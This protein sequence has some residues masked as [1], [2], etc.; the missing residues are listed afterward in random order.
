MKLTEN[1]R[2]RLTVYQLGKVASAVLVVLA[3]WNVIDAG[4]AAALTSALTAI[5]GLFG[6]GASNVAASTV[7]KQINDGTLDF[8]GSAAQQAVEAMGAVAAQAQASVSDLDKVKAA[9]ADLAGSVPVV[10]PLAQQVID[11]VTLT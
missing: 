7:S 9:A 2:T 10:G 11:S 1:P 3:A 4:S 6:F 5:L 8:T